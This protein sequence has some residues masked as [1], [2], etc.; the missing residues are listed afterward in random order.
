MRLVFNALAGLSLLLGIATAALWV[1]AY[2]SWDDLFV[3]VRWSSSAG[4]KNYPVSSGPII[5]ISANNLT[6]TRFNLMN[7]SGAVFL[8]LLY[9]D[10]SR[11]HENDAPR[12]RVQ[13][14]RYHMDA[15]E[16]AWLLHDSRNPHGVRG[17][18]NSVFA[19]VD[20]SGIHDVMILRQYGVSDWF[21][22]L[23][24]SPLPGW[25]LIDRY[26]T[27]RRIP[28]CCADCG[29]D[30]RATPDRCPECG[31]VPVDATVHFEDP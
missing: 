27:H 11:P 4:I 13:F 22:L 19:T 14:N 2:Y 29:Y 10:E 12:P 7:L 17:G 21:L 8:Q 25:W 15:Y 20:G 9:V 6:G 30:L 3:F 23:I 18:R 24:F 5:Y 1:R 26:R 28:G 31:A 16:R